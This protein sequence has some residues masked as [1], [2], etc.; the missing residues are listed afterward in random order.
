MS[1]Y[2][3]IVLYAM[4]AALIAA[5]SFSDLPEDIQ[6]YSAETTEAE[7]P[8][9]LPVEMILSAD[10]AKLDQS[11][12][13]IRNLKARAARLRQRAKL[14]RLPVAEAYDRLQM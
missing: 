11:L 6:T 12:A 13:D 3:H 5:C 14:L 7:W 8:E 10:T 9:F 1:S 4:A 2:R